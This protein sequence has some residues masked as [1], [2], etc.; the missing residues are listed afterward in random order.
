[1]SGNRVRSD[2]NRLGSSTRPRVRESVAITIRSPAYAR[3]AAPPL[4]AS[5]LYEAR[6]NQITELAKT[7]EQAYCRAKPDYFNGDCRFVWLSDAKPRS[8]DMEFK[9][10]QNG[11]F[12]LKQ[13][14]EFHGQ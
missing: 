12:V 2:K 8:L 7:V 13:A 9:F 10:L 4:T 6:M 5:V 14:R 3:T 1:M 11:Q